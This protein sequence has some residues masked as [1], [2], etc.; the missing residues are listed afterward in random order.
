MAYD[1]INNNF[2]KCKSYKIVIKEFKE[3]YKQ[4]DEKTKKLNYNSNHY[5][6]SENEFVNFYINKRENNITIITLIKVNEYNKNEY[7]KY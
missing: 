3:F 2:K 5:Q 7:K 6:I 1:E 4:I